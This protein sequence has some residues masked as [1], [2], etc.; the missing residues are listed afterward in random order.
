MES[1]KETLQENQTQNKKDDMATN[2]NKNNL[3]KSLDEHH[4]LE[5]T[6]QT[7]ISNLQA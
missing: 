4:L 7:Q 3:S 6:Q 1:E 2:L 5:H